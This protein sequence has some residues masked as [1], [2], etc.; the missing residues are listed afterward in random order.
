M[1]GCVQIFY[2]IVFEFLARSIVQRGTMLTAAIATPWVWAFKSF[3]FGPQ[4]NP[5]SNIHLVLAGYDILFHIN[6]KKGQ[7]FFSVVP[8]QCSFFLKSW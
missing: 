6:G 8:P 3:F 2:F 1:V 7:E 5:G 4:N